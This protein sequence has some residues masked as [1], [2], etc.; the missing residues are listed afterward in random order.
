M[1][2]GLIARGL[3]GIAL[4]DQGILTIQVELLI[5]QVGLGRRLIRLGDRQVGLGAIQGG[6]EGCLIDLIEQFVLGHHGPLME[7][8]LGQ[9]ALDPRLQFHRLDGLDG[10]DEAFLL[11]HQP[12]L[13]R[14]D[15]H[16][17]QGGLFRAS[18]SRV[19]GLGG[20][21]RRGLAGPRGFQRGGPGG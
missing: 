7:G 5:Q 2:L 11:V 8:Q 20:H 12:F 6:L 3:G 14:R 1:G 4:L 16:R 19:G 9:E 13:D 10:P 21:A 17:G 15:H 18:G